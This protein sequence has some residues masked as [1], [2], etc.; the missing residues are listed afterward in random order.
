MNWH[1]IGS[2]AFGALSPLVVGVLIFILFG[3]I[4]AWFSLPEDYHLNMADAWTGGVVLV[5]IVVVAI[6]VLIRW[7]G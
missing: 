6:A 1:M 2:Y 3:G 7:V 4:A 5:G